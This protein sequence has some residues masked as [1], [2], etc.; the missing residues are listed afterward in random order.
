MDDFSVLDAFGD[1]SDA[2]TEIKHLTFTI[3]ESDF[4]EKRYTYSTYSLDLKLY[5]NIVFNKRK[6]TLTLKN[7][8]GIGGFLSSLK[9]MMRNTWNPVAFEFVLV[10]GYGNTSNYKAK[11][12]DNIDWTISPDVV[13]IELNANAEIIPEESV[14]SLYLQLI[15]ERIEEWN[16]N[17]D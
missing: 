1:M 6:I 12:N 2:P 16:M 7:Q 4:A 17:D 14:E 13:T 8:I 11:L 5:R 9:K 15:D 10:D 3:K